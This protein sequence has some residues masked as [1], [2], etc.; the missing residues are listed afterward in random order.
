MK[1]K[2]NQMSGRIE[3]E[4]KIEETIQ[5]KL[6]ELP[7]FVSEWNEHLNAA[8]TQATTRRDFVN[9]VGRFLGS[10][11]EDPKQ[12]DVKDLSQNQIEKYLI[13][14]KTKETKD[15]IVHTSYSYRQ[16][17]WTCLNNFF[18]YLYD[19][20]YIEENYMNK[21]KKIK[22]SDLNRIND[23]RKLLT[24]EEFNKILWHVSYGIKYDDMKKRDLAIFM[25]FMTTGMRETALQEINVADIDFENH[26]L[27]VIDKGN[28]EHKYYL[29]EKTMECINNWLE[30]RNYFTRTKYNNAL[31]IS[32]RGNRMH[33]NTI[34]KMIRKYSEK[35]LG[36]SISPHKLR[37]GLCSILYE[38]W[39]DI[40]KVR[41][42]IGHANIATTQ[43]YIVTGNTERME[44]SDMLQNSLA[45]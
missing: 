20:N 9:K 28:K 37:S 38:E 42:A 1:R 35:A 11:K 24:I 30:V 29:N 7:F 17:V 12:V 10:I 25:I 21:I 8:G 43:R 18:Q 36:Y 44:V 2:E 14:I 5:K 26:I 31:F 22:G 33:Q 40:E 39:G 6:N 27:I 34:S 32:S 13:R 41:R 15:G 19:V 4:I 16:S 23:N 3:N 45:V